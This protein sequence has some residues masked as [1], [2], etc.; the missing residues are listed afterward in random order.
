MMKERV[1]DGG[2]WVDWVRE[3][4]N[5]ITDSRE[6]LK[7]IKKKFLDMIESFINEPK[8]PIKIFDTTVFDLNSIKNAFSH[9]I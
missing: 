6:G 9:V 1:E 4:A 8:N 5:V 7:N 2:F 3:A